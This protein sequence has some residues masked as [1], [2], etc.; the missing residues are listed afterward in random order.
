MLL[1]STY[2]AKQKDI[3]NSYLETLL[4]VFA[5]FFSFIPDATPMIRKLI[6]MITIKL[7]RNL[8]NV[9]SNIFRNYKIF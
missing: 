7:K 3:K 2:R 5:V 4:N 8:K 1:S 9:V 6:P